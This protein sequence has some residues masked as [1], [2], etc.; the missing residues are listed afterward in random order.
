MIAG[1]SALPF[2]P[3]TG[4][5]ASTNTI[6]S[7][8]LGLGVLIDGVACTTPQTMNWTAGSTH[9]LSVTSPQTSGRVRATFAGRSAGSGPSITASPAGAGTVTG[10]LTGNSPQTIVVNAP[11][12]VTANFDNTAPVITPNL[13][14]TLGTNG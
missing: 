11:K 2:T 3:P 10:D 7:N 9:T 6:A 4:S 12:S 8:L 1:E 14:G 13:S 5:A